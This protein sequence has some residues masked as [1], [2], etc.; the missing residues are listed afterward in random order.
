MLLRPSKALNRII[1]GIL[2]RAQR[3]Y[4]MP[5]HALVVMSTH[6]HMLLSPPDSLRLSRFMGFVNANLS[7]EVGKLHGWTGALWHRRYD[8]FV[9]S[10]EEAAQVA[11]LTY[12]LSNGCK[13]NLVSTPGDWPGVHSVDAMVRGQPLVGTWIDR[14]RLS[15]RDVCEDMLDEFTTEEHVVLSPLPV[16]SHLPQDTY[17]RRV[18]EIVQ[19]IAEE[20]A[21]RHR[22]D[23]TAPLGVAAILRT[24]PRSSA[25]RLERRAKPLVHAFR[26][27]VRQAMTDQFRE[28]LAAYR[29]ASEAWRGG[30]FTASFPP[31]SFRPPGRWVGLDDFDPG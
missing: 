7:K 31:G 8:H 28:W 18:G 17:R 25:Q 1:L 12:L 9:V 27:R 23:G 4:G 16:W 26:R 5:I 3:R 11:R 20:T 21:E 14:T 30:D 22:R 24:H 29:R 6:Y 2:G 15:Q 13:E 19:Q 10:D